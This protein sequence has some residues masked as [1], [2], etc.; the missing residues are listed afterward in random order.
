MRA[1]AAAAGLAALLAL[2][3]ALGGSASAART[4]ATKLGTAK[5]KV[6]ASCP[7]T[8]CEAVGSVTGFQKQA[9]GRRGLFKMPVPGKIVAWSVDVAKPSSE[10]I[11]FFGSFYEH[12]KLG[13]DPFARLAVLRRKPKKGGRFKLQKHSPKVQLTSHLGSRPI[14]A[15]RRPLG[16][17]KGDVIAITVP[18]WAPIF[19]VGLSDR[20]VWVASRSKEKCSGVENIKSGRP[21]QKKGSL[22]R[23]GCTYTT[24][25]LTYWA[26][27]VPNKKT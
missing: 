11:S 20:N 27:F 8:P 15:M 10:Q 3:I 17:V 24:A 1:I 21:H 4:E 2:V 22:R 5:G 9:A 7:K 18:T 23:F 26:Y 19:D 13:T 6:K 25:R 14:F 12:D 16:A